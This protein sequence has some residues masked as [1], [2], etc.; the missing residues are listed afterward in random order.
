MHKKMQKISLEK[1]RKNFFS[2][3]HEKITFAEFL[4]KSSILKFVTQI[5]ESA[6]QP[7]IDWNPFSLRQCN[8]FLDKIAS[9]SK[10]IFLE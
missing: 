9:F 7:R 1:A 6:E 5:G 10:E 2:F 4:G 8:R 3:A